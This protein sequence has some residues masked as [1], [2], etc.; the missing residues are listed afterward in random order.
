MVKAIHKISLYLMISI[1]LST[2]LS[3]APF[4]KDIDSKEAYALAKK[5][6][7]LIDVRTKREFKR[8]HA[9]GAVNIPI[10]DEKDG[11]REFNENFVAQIEY[12][13]NDDYSKPI[14]L[15]CRSGAR[16][17]YAAEI[18]GKNGFSTLYNVKKGFLM[19]EG[20]LFYK[21]PVEK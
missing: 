19:R 14:I 21:L 17:A 7:M 9:K 8:L 6:A 12:T 5:G 18:L 13:V 1:L 3:A 4:Y 2:I 20:W 16:S 15:I 10:F 11:R